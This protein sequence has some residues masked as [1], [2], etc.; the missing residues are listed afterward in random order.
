MK[1][2]PGRIKPMEP[3]LCPAPFDSPQHLFEIK[4]DGMRLVSFIKDRRVRLQNRHLRE[5]TAFFP[6]LS[7]LHQYVQAGTAVLD[8]EL[9]VL[10]D[11]RPSFPLLMKRC[12]VNPAR[13][14]SLVQ[15]L[16]VVYMV[17]DLLYL[18]GEDLTEKPLVKRREL[19]EKIFETAPSCSL[20]PAFEETGRSLFEAIKKQEMEGIVA[21][22][23]DTPYLPGKKSRHWLKIKNRRKQ[24]IAI[25]GFTLKA[26]NLN[27]ILAG[28]FLGDQF[29]YLGRVGAGLVTVAPDLLALLKKLRINAPPFQPPPCLKMDVK[30]VAPKIVAEVEY[31]EWTPDLKLRQPVF[32]R[33]V[34]QPI[35][36]CLLD[37]QRV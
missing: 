7:D 11:N 35:S 9:V 28:A 2:T 3:V 19:L 12:L 6:E 1:W 17:F 29:K 34:E 36:S 20:S 8:G 22:G 16:P 37:S 25:G 5:K 30:W 26:Q 31:Q 4:W 32:K 14:T 24:L 10:A 13:N 18:N 23:R 21:K 27:A 15:K 33:L